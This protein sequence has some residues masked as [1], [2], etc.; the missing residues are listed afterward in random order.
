MALPAGRLWAAAAALQSVQWDAQQQ[1]SKLQYRYCIIWANTRNHFSKSARVFDGIC[2]TPIRTFVSAPYQAE[3]FDDEY[4]LT[5]C[6]ES[7]SWR[8]VERG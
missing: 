2:P 5:L 1:T 6:S 8:C 4:P 7:D 3:K